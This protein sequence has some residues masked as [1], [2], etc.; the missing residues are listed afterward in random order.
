MTESLYAGFSQ[1]IS[2]PPGE[3]PETIVLNHPRA[4]DVWVLWQALDRK[5]LPS[6]ILDEPEDLLTDM[7]T[8]DS[9]Y[10]VMERKANA[11]KNN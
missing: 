7:L 8:L 11:N 2:A 10:N 9:L 1:L 5:F 3:L 4:Y 6:Q